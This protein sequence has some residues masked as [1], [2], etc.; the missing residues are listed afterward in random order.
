MNAVAPTMLS[1][2]NVPQPE[3]ACW[4]PSSPSA[5]SIA[6]YSP[7]LSPFMIRCCQSMLTWT[8]VIP[9]SRSLWITCSVIPMLRIRI[10]IAGSEFLCSR[11]SLTPCSA[12]ISAAS[13]IPS[14][15]HSH[16]SAYGVWNG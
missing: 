9:R 4:C 8:F 1:S 15:N 2:S 11:K 7:R 14:R 10:F 12:Q 6:A 16:D 13:A 5:A 3:F